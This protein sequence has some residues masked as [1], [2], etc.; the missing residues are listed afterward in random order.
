MGFGSSFEEHKTSNQN[1]IRL[2]NQMEDQ[3]AIIGMG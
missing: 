1:L 2:G 3:E